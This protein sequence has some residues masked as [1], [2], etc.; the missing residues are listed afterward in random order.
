MNARTLIESPDLALAG[1]VAVT[2]KGEKL[3]DLPQA[4]TKENIVVIRQPT[5]N[6]FI[7]KGWTL[8]YFMDSPASA[9]A[10]RK[11]ELPYLL[12]PSGTGMHGGNPI[13][14]VW[15]RQF[16]KPGT[17]H[18][19]GLLQ[20]H[21]DE[22]HIY[23]DMMS[24]RS[25][26][27]RNRINSL[28]IDALRKQYPEAKLSFSDAT[29]KGRKFISSYTGARKV[30]EAATRERERYIHIGVVDSNGAVRAK[31][32]GYFKGVNGGETP[33]HSALRLSGAARWRYP[34][35]SN[36]VF[37][38]E[39]TYP[40]EKH[41][42][43]NYLAKRG[44]T[45][46][47]H[48]EMLDGTPEDDMAAGHIPLTKDYVREAANAQPFPGSQVQQLVYHGTGQ[49]FRRF[50]RGTQG[51]IWFASDPAPILAREVGAQGHGYIVSAYINVQNPAGWKAYDNLLLAQFRGEGLDGAVLPNRNGFDCFV[52]DPNQ[53][54]IVEVKPL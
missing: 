18:I 9:Q 40:E 31:R 51:I 33:T 38:W 22:G 5:D 43:E 37:W 23:I 39:G 47:R 14:D 36:T 17:Q 45:G 53:V 20:G 34:E 24:V 10:M 32:V 48:R 25:K 11:G 15:K 30:I 26:W 19:L 12:V 2:P 41:A 8:V 1:N 42:V 49:K 50:K 27:Q 13:T 28:M 54:R 16:Q 44:F 35:G 52:F 21:S 4:A 46:L 29:D 7:A 3:R 6:A